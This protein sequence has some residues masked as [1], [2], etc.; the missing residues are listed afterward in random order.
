MPEG[1]GSWT[2]AGRRPA[3]A[4]A[5]TAANATPAS[6]AR[7]TAA[8]IPVPR[9]PPGAGAAPPGAAPASAL[10]ALWF[11]SAVTSAPPS[12]RLGAGARLSSDSRPPRPAWRARPAMTRRGTGRPGRARAGG[13][14][15]RLPGLA[16][17]QA[18]RDGDD[19]HASGE[20]ER[21]RVRHGVDEEADGDRAGDR[22]GVPGHLVGGHHRPALT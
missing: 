9:R 5:N 14:A 19:K 2:A 11:T 4:N 21:G 12:S 8:A 17:R 18:E 10:L 22:A 3:S 20:A 7:A 1:R 16:R 15:G 6:T 13:G